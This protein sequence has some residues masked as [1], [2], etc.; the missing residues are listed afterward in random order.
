MDDDY[1]TVVRPDQIVIALDDP[2][3]GSGSADDIPPRPVRPRGRVNT[4]AVL[5]A[6]TLIGGLL[7][8][9]GILAFVLISK[10][11]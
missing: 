10:E 5:I 7:V 6:G 9:V 3:P 2:A 11:S 1:D 4:I 8:L